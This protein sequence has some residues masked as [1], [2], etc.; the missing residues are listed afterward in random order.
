MSA[1]FDLS[2]VLQQR[3]AEE[4]W[5]RRSANT[6]TTVVTL[7]VNVLWVLISLG[8]HVDPAVIGA[9]AAAIQALGV[10]GIKMT[11]NGVT[12]RQIKEIEGYVGKHRE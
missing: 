11:P 5:W 8:V 7:G 1:P 9:V 10:V 2:Q 6:V 3:L 4:P 12:E